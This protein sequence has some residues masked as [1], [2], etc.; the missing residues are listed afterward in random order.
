MK[1]II[2]II[3]ILFAVSS[4]QSCTKEEE[5]YEGSVVFWYKEDLANILASIDVTSLKYYIDGKLVGTSGNVYWKGAPNCGQNG[6]TTIKLDLGIAKSRAY[7]YS[8]RDQD[9]IEYWDGVVNI[10]ANTCLKFELTD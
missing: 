8:V 2:Y 7:S 5:E 3:A 1:K 4:L 10:D 9:G 6:A